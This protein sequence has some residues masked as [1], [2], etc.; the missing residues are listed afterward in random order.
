MIKYYSSGRFADIGNG[1]IAYF[2]NYTQDGHGGMAYEHHVEM[3][4]IAAEVAER[5]IKELVP[6]MA[7]DIYRQSLGDVLRGLRYDVE[8]VV[9]IAFENG[10]D[11]FTS[12][13]ARKVVSDAVY[14][15]IIKGLEKLEFKI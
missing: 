12:S 9:N 14:K 10:R 8:T 3:R 5:K 13:K 6:Q 2:P 11:I 15:E 4:E 1:K 7:R